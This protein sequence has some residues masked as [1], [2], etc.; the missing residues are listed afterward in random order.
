[1]VSSCFPNDSSHRRGSVAILAQ[2]PQQASGGPRRPTGA[3]W[4]VDGDAS[5]G[6]RR[7]RPTVGVHFTLTMMNSPTVGVYRLRGVFLTQ[8]RPP[9]RGRAANAG[10]EQRTGGSR[11]CR[12]RWCHHQ[13]PHPPPKAMPKSSA[14]FKALPESQGPTSTVVFLSGFGCKGQGKPA[15]HGGASRSVGQSFVASG[16]NPT[17]SAFLSLVSWRR[18]V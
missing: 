12:L 17:T 15:N 3:S 6:G 11:R 4:N 16:P 7:L 14:G 1:M 13:N 2:V 10:M 9:F 18:G 8:E 5:I